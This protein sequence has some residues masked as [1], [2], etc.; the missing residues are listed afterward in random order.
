VVI[1]KCLADE[2]NSIK[3]LSDADNVDAKAVLASAIS[4]HENGFS[5]LNMIHSVS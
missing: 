1:Q 2:A 5:R 3:N 4:S